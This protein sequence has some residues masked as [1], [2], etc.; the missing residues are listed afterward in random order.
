M[1]TATIWLSS[2]FGLGLLMR[3]IGLPP[4]IGFLAAGFVLSFLG[5]ETN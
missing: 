1:I 5:H 2:A 3:L 4:L